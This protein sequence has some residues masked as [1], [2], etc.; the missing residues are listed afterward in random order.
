MRLDM[1]NI[2]SNSFNNREKN[3]TTEYNSMKS[4]Y[5]IFQKL[6]NGNEPP[7]WCAFTTYYQTYYE[8]D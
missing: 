4:S 8:Y 6:V 1:K 2:Q 5:S 3:W 7:V